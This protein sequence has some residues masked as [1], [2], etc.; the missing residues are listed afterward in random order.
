[1]RHMVLV[2]VKYRP[3]N[4]KV[5]TIMKPRVVRGVDSSYNFVTNTEFTYIRRFEY[6]AD[7]KENEIFITYIK[8]GSWRHSIEVKALFRVK[9]GAKA[10]IPEDDARI[11]VENAEAVAYVIFTDNEFSEAS[12]ENAEL[13]IAKAGN[14]KKILEAW[15]A[16]NLFKQTVPEGQQE[17]QQ[18]SSDLQYVPIDK[19]IIPGWAREI[20]REYMSESVKARG[21]IVPVILAKTPDNRLILVDGRGRIEIAKSRGDAKIPARIIPVNSEEEAI[22]LAIEM[23]K[24]KKEWS[25]SYMLKLINHLLQK[26]YSKTKIAEMLKISRSVLYRYLYATEI[27]NNLPD[28]LKQKFLDELDKYIPLKKFEEINAV[29]NKAGISLSDFVKIF[30]TFYEEV[31]AGIDYNLSRAYHAVLMLIDDEIVAWQ[32]VKAAKKYNIKTLL[33]KIK[34]IEEKEKKKKEEKKKEEAPAPSTPPTPPQPTVPEGQQEEVREVVVTIPEEAPTT[35]TTPTPQPEKFIEDYV[36]TAIN[37]ITDLL[38]ELEEIQDKIEFLK[39]V[40]AWIENQIRQLSS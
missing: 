25:H 12:F 1:M 29:C 19:I 27:Y 36:E 32:L 9:K 17:T 23:E 28:E 21:V 3:S 39:R 20:D 2:T 18:P 38:E 14:H 31:G 10:A 11:E 8:T 30:I 34:E 5:T 35:P 7:I 40:K 22:L 6:A 37:A 15:A 4:P 33:D 26:G 24:T 13:Y 16:E